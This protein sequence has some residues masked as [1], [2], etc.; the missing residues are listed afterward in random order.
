[1]ILHLDGK[2]DY[3]GKCT[4]RPLILTTGPPTRNS[5]RLA[6]H[7]GAMAKVPE[8]LHRHLTNLNLMEARLNASR[9]CVATRMIILSGLA[10][11]TYGA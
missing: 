5:F 3:T 11:A 2:R 9:R 4:E 6:R 1:M 7:S 10:I 8:P